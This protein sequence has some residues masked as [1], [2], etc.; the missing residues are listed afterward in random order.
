MSKKAA[1]TKDH[2]AEALKPK[3][4]KDLYKM[5]VKIDR[6]LYEKA[7]PQLEGKFAALMEGAIREAL[8]RLKSGKVG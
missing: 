1:P 5:T 8:D 4:K 3:P 2:I 6:E 7:L